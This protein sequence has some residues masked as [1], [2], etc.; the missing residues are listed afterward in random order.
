MRGAA[1]LAPLCAL[2]ALTACRAGVGIPAMPN[3]PQIPTTAHVPEWL[4]THAATA[5]CGGSLANQAQCAVLVKTGGT[6]ESTPHGWSPPQLQAAYQLPS[7]SKGKGTLVAIVDA[8]DSPTVASDLAYYRS[9]FKLPKA[10]FAKYNQRGQKKNYPRLPP[11]SSDWD[12]EIDLDV[13]MLSASC[14]N[15]RIALIEADSNSFKDLAAAEVE[16]VKLGAHIV[17]NSWYGSC[18]GSC[19]VTSY[20]KKGVTYL[21]CAGDIGYGIGVPARFDTVVAVGGTVLTYDGS[22]YHETVWRD[23]GG[24]CSSEA[25]PSWQHDPG[26]S[27]RTANDVAAVSGCCVA[28]YD[29]TNYNGWIEAYGTSVATPLLA[30]AFAL[31]GNAEQQDG[32]KTF[33]TMSKAARARSLHDITSGSDGTCKPTYLC[34]AGTKEFGTYSGPTGWGTPKGIAAF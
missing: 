13:D 32:G 25:K 30:G 14:P 1:F 6:G 19:Y 23:T 20:Q 4:A 21:A 17:S 33:W 31:A 16:A 3:D 7:A 34:T 29:T 22:N 9:Y 26:C 10:Q 2:L 28:E 15:C 11:S 18:V 27:G 12:L 24:G 8:Y 5:A